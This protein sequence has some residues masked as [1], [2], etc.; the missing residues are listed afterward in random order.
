MSVALSA[1]WAVKVLRTLL[2]AGR[3]RAQEVRHTILM[4]NLAVDQRHL[5]L[6]SC[7]ILPKEDSL[8]HLLLSWYRQGIFLVVRITAHGISDLSLIRSSTMVVI[9]VIH[10]HSARGAL[11]QLGPPAGCDLRRFTIAR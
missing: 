1:T 4:S 6:S 7:V 8:V 10:S 3:I 2:V 11:L 5:F 9:K